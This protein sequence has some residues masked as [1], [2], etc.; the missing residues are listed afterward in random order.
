MCVTSCLAA[1]FL[2]LCLATFATSQD[3]PQTPDRVP[4][5]AMQNLLIRKVNPVYPPLA[6]QAHIQGTVILKIVINKSGNVQSLQLVKGHPM[7]APAAFEAVRQWKYQPYL[8]N[9]EAVEVETNMQVNFVL[10]PKPEADGTAGDMPG[11][12]RPGAIGIAKT[13]DPQSPTDPRTPK[14]VRVSENVMQALLIHRVDPVPPAEPGMNI[15]GSV[16]L[17]AVIDK[18]GHVQ[19]LQLVSG[20]P[21]LVPAALEAARQWKYQPFL[22]N[23]DPVEVETIVRVD[24]AK[25][26]S[27]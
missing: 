23:G 7:L 17:K 22:L 5:D 10:G 18:S 20:H 16:V 2:L 1:S 27:K 25:P 6:R 15:Q 8:S 11:G 13:T 26:K 4:G 19:Q 9:G 3:L 24:F 14:R 12:L 21:L